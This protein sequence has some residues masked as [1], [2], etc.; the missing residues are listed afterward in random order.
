MS[1]MPK[2]QPQSVADPDAAPYDE[3]MRR[4][5]ARNEKLQ[6]VL[7]FAKSH[8]GA[9]E[10]VIPVWG[11]AREAVADGFEGDAAGAVLN[12]VLA[13]SDLL[14]GGAVVKGVAKGAVF[15]AKE[16]SKRAA[17]YGW[18]GN[19]R[20]WMGEQGHL[21]KGQHGHHWAIPQNG[22]GKQV[23]DWIKNQPWNIKGMPSPEA[24][25]RIHQSVGGKP[26]FNPAQRYWY[27]TPAWAK[28]AKVSTV[29]HPT[30]VATNRK[31]G[32]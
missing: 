18:K 22:W 27:G 16:G 30:A 26:R 28:A 3:T 15:V 7:E 2:G 32:S 24:H 17:P 23:P 9:A 29:G 8:P 14:L 21:A 25:L 31:P 11:S 19:V 12:G 4:Q 5:K 6:Q 13:G 10:S 1:N 20:T